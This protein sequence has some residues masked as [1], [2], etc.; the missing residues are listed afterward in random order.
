MNN[1]RG[2]ATVA[3]IIIAV[4]I[5]AAGLLYWYIFSN[6]QA[7]PNSQP[8]G[9]SPNAATNQTSTAAGGLGATIYQQSQNPIQGKV[10]TTNP[11]VNPIE[12]AYK[13]P[14]Q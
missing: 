1:Q 9:L 5:A 14:F 13:N 3:T 10:P 2:F 8:A 7:T 4:A 11:A 6:R 12:G